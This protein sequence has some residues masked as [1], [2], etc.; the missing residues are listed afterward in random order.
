MDGAGTAA[1]PVAGTAEA[2]GSITSVG[3]ASDGVVAACGAAA[4]AAPAVAGTSAAAASAISHPVN[5]IVVPTL[6][7]FGHVALG[8]P[9][10]LAGPKVA[11]L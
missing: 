4:V 10:R 11:A 7:G 1:A 6:I 2:A 8:G 9:P 3:A 5:F